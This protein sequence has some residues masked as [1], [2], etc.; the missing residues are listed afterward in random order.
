MLVTT[1]EHSVWIII[2]APLQQWLYVRNSLLNYTST[3]VHFLFCY[4]LRDNDFEV[5][6][7][8]YCPV[9]LI[10]SYGNI[11]VLLLLFF[12]YSFVQCLL[13]MNYFCTSEVRLSNTNLFSLPH[14]H[15]V[16][17]TQIL[18]HKSCADAFVMYLCTEFHKPGFNGSFVE[19]TKKEDQEIVCTAE[20]FLSYVRVRCSF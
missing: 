3:Y 5:H 6:H 16:F 19:T 12:S 10:C 4:R 13:L 2:I 7:E 14:I 1:K 20:L 17:E 11:E 18:F 9:T 15:A 8:D